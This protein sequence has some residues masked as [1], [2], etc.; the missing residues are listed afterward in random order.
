MFTV[1][2]CSPLARLSVVTLGVADLDKANAFYTAVFGRGPNPDF[3][4]VCFFDLPGTWISLY[5]IDKL[6][7]DIAPSLPVAA[8]PGGAFNGITLAHNVR[9]REEAVAVMEKARAAGATVVKPPEETFWGG[10]SG[11][12]ADPDGY[13]WEVVWAPMFDFAPDGSMRFRK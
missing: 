9:S 4:G 13:Y 6:A 10:F 3:E 1:M 5:P 2:A 8:R 11:Y 12:F 7:E